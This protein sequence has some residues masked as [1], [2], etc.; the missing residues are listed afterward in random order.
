MPQVGADLISSPNTPEKAAQLRDSFV[1]TMYSTTFDWLLT[2]INLSLRL[3]SGDEAMA[4]DVAPPAQQF[5]GILDI[6]GFETFEAGNS[7]E[8]VPSTRLPST[9]SWWLLMATDLCR[10]PSMATYDR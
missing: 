10:W 8:Q 1:R 7:M 2:K 4:A 5:V 9:V 6:F 3:R